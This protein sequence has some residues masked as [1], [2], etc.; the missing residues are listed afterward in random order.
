MFKLR[1]MMMMYQ[2][3]AQF[4][5]VMI[6]VTKILLMRLFN[7]NGNGSD[8]DHNVNDDNDGSED[9][10]TIVG[11]DVNDKSTEIEESEVV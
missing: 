11:N 1:L 4:N 3:H 8:D 9:D 7:H 5:N 6:S 2:C 10:A